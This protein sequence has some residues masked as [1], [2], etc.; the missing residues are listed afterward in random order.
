[1]LVDRPLTSGVCR[2]WSSQIRR[3]RKSTIDVIVV[4][5]Y[6]KEVVYFS[7]REDFDS[8]MDHPLMQEINLTAM[9]EPG[10]A[11]ELSILSSEC[12]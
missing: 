10:I 7:Q 11:R 9:S 12:I 2:L 1:M 5:I 3:K 8:R 4:I 6:I